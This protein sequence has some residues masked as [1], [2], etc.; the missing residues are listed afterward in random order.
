MHRNLNGFNPKGR[1][2][3]KSKIEKN[4][5]YFEISTKTNAGII[6]ITVLMYLIK[7]LNN[8]HF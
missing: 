5:L 3:D 2:Y 8:L 4:I 6:G 1:K 7:N